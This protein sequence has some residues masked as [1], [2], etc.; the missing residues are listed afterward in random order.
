MK[1]GIIRLVKAGR[2][3]CCDYNRFRLDYVKRI[4]FNTYT[5]CTL[6]PVTLNRII[7]NIYTI[8]YRYIFF[9]NAASAKIGFIFSPLILRFLL[10]LVT[11]FPFSSFKITSRVFKSVYDFIQLFGHC[12]S[13]SSLTIPSASFCIINVILRNTSICYVCVKCVGA[14]RQD[15]RFSLYVPFHI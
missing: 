15:S 12:K 10:P 11:Y 13:K 9:C 3:A 6:Y 1:S 4:V 2:T 7:N 8:K 5:V 14:L